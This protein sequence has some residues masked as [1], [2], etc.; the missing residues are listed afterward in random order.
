VAAPVQLAE[1]TLPTE[2]AAPIE[3][4]TVS[5]YRIVAPLGGGGMGRVYEAEDMRLGRHVAVKFL[6]DAL[7]RDPQ[8]VE[9]FQREARAASALDHPGICVVHDVGEFEGRPFIAME[10]LEGTTLKHRIDGRPMALEAFLDLAIDLTDAL[11][12]AHAKGIV[13]RD[14]KPA[15]IFVTSRGQPKILDFGLAKQG[16][17]RD[18]DGLSDAPTASAGE[19]LR[20]SPGTLLGTVAYMSPEQAR[21]L[22]LDARTDLFSFGAVLFEMATGKPPFDGETA[23]VVFDAILNRE[24]V[25]PSALN[26]GVPGEVDRIVQKALE[27][28][29]DVRYQ[30]ARDLH[31]DLRRLRRDSS[32]ARRT[33]PA[34]LRF[35]GGAWK[36]PRR[37]PGPVAAAATAL[38]ALA[39]LALHLTSPLPPPRVAGYR[40][41]TADR[42]QKSWPLTDGARVYFT[43]MLSAGSNSLK[44]VA[45]T[46]GHVAEIELPFAAPMLADLS[47]AGSELLVIGDSEAVGTTRGGSPTRPVATSTWPRATGRRR[48]GSGPLPS[49]PT[50]PRGRPTDGA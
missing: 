34:S 19:K 35:R 37:R 14:I 40:E 29:R 11:D 26:P 28:D 21:G 6:S 47:P 27:K 48:S 20:T 22:P 49:P 5:H 7:A 32:S 12:A 24:P 41:L 43:E 2:W 1:K 4:R 30:T 42:E 31:A 16:P 33:A 8:A 46:G 9:R 39:A 15:N 17:G 23:A 18:G 36:W 45:T 3:G 44:Q 10:L 50:S 13:H 25:P 38:L